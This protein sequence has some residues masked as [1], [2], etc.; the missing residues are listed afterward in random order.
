MVGDSTGGAHVKKVG[1]GMK[2][3]DPK[4]LR[5]VRLEEESV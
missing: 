3:L 4:G 5:H 1:C 2:G